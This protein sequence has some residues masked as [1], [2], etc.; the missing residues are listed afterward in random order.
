M[1]SMLSVRWCT[2]K[3]VQRIGTGIREGIRGGTRT[4]R[5]TRTRGGTGTG[6][7]KMGE[8]G[9]RG[10][11]KTGGATTRRPKQHFFR[12]TY[13]RNGVC[14]YVRVPVWD[15]YTYSFIVVHVHNCKHPCIDN[16][17]VWPP[18]CWISESSGKKEKGFPRIVPRQKN[19]SIGARRGVYDWICHI[20]ESIILIF[21]PMFFIVSTAIIVYVLK[22][23]ILMIYC[24][25][26]SSGN[27]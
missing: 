24:R 17:Y 10:E 8:I 12:H 7:R 19:E 21:I 26:N 13:C 11:A 15:A 9:T 27:N 1:C 14:A 6:T 23:I 25:N 5:W 20:I 18:T 16:K 3:S 2:W 22:R 4:S